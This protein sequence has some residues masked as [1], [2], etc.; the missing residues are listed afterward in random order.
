V[1]NVVALSAGLGSPTSLLTGIAPDSHYA[2]ITAAG[3]SEFS[4]PDAIHSVVGVSGA[5]AGLDGTNLYEPFGQTTTN[6]TSFP[7]AFTGR[8]PVAGTS[9]YYFRSRF[10]DPVAGRFLSEDSGPLPGLN[11]YRYLNNN[12]RSS[13][14]PFG[15]SPASLRGIG[16]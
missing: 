8:V 16:R 10:Y 4:L 6:G 2:T 1:T 7:F 3:Q 9:I 15:A 14:N 11:L 13:S 12:P 5:S